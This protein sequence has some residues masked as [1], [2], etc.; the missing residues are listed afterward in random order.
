VINK[1]KQNIDFTNFAGME[2]E[3]VV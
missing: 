1:L 2:I 3:S